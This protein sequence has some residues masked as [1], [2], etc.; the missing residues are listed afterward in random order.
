M[1]QFLGIYPK[2]SKS[3]YTRETCTPLL[4][5]ALF[6]IAKIWDQPRCP[7]TVDWIRKVW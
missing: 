1:I 4:I 6:T 2:K 7:S 5:V 3:A